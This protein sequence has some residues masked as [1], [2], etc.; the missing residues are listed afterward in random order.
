MVEVKKVKEESSVDSAMEVRVAACSSLSYGNCDTPVLRRSSVLGYVVLFQ[1]IKFTWVFVAFTMINTM[2]HQLLYFCFMHY[3]DVGC[4]VI[5]GGR[6]VQQD[7]QGKEAG[8]K[9]RSVT[10]NSSLIFYFGMQNIL[11]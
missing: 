3:D 1:L 10:G 7:A 9:K 5:E 4:C 6:L 2:L 8:Q 11:L